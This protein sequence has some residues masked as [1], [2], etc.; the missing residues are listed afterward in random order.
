MD[1]GCRVDAL[2]HLL[3]KLFVPDQACLQKS[4]GS[5]LKTDLHLCGL[6][7]TQWSEQ[8]VRK[9]ETLVKLIL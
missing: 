4:R 6:A 7:L 8:I 5:L 9:L 2:H 1:R 3:T